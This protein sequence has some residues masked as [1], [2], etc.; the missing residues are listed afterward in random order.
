MKR[1]TSRG[2][3]DRLP[4]TTN[5]VITRFRGVGGPVRRTLLVSV[6]TKSDAGLILRL[7]LKIA[8][9]VSYSPKSSFRPGCIMAVLALSWTN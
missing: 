1:S 2:L 9:Y 7:R 5:S 4:A 6:L 8:V 3:E